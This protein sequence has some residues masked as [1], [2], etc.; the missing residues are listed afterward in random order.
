MSVCCLTSSTSVATAFSLPLARQFAKVVAVENSPA[1][2]QLC[3]R[4]ANSAGLG[5]IRAICSEVSYWMDSRNAD[6]QELFDLI[7]LDPPR[8]GAGPGIMDRIRKWSPSNIIYVSCDPQTLVR[9]LARI[10]PADYKISLVAG[11]DMFPQTY[12]FET[13]VCLQKH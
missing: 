1:A 5:N 3:A 10:S 9:D 13:V 8:T 4:N 6:A 2:V 7:V 11:L 12:H